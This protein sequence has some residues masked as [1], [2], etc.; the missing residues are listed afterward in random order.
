MTPERRRHI[1]RTVTSSDSENGETIPLWGKI[2]Y[3]FDPPLAGWNTNSDGWR[4]AASP[5][6]SLS[7]SDEAIEVR[8]FGPFRKVAEAFGGPLSLPPPETVMWTT[9]LGEYFGPWRVPWLKRR[10]WLALSYARSDGVEY[11]LAVRP[12]DGDFVHLRA[13]LRAAGVRE[14]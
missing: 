5:S 11:T 6:M 2:R 12:A 10:E 4:Y 13:A 7:I 1:V 8:G 3:R 14:S 9:S